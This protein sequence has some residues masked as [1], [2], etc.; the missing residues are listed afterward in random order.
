MRYKKMHLGTTIFSGRSEKTISYLKNH[1]RSLE[2]SEDERAYLIEVVDQWSDTPVPSHFFPFVESELR[3][4]TL[5]ALIGLRTVISELQ[6]PVPIGEKLY[7]KVQ[8]LN[9]SGSPGFGLI[10]GLVKAL[11]NRFDDLAST[12][13][14]GL[15]SENVDIA[16]GA[17]VGLHHWLMASAEVAS[18]IQPP[19]NDLVREIGIMIATR[20]KKALGQALEIAK[21]VFDEGND[22]QKEAIRDLALQGLG[23]LVEELRYDREHDLDADVPFLRWACAHLALAMAECGLGDDLAVSRWLESAKEDPLPE[24]RYAKN[25]DFAQS[26]RERESAGDEPSSQAD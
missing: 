21:W 23:Y 14:M 2:L 26:S 11:P 24:V 1:Q 3:E 19:P 6:I 5:Q 25:S 9:E 20:R 16:E 8:G 17:A 7:K 18:H 13:R 10:A 15:V 22:A 4:P 12:M